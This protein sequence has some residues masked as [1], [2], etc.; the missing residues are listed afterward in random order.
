VTTAEEYAAEHAAIRDLTRRLGE[1]RAR[2]ISYARLATQ[3]RVSYTRLQRRTFAL[4]ASERQ[5]VEAV[6]DRLE[7]RDRCNQ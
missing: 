4:D 3:A 7:G 5:R 2:G 1:A 6:L